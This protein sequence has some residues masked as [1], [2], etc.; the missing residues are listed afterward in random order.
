VRRGQ[1]TFVFTVDA[2]GLTRIRPIM[3]GTMAAER[4]EALA[5]VQAGD[6][7][8]LSPPPALSDGARITPNEPSASAEG[9]G[10]RR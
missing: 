10:D 6:R 8:V 2:D 1:L 7:V 3:T 9:A 5:G 4:V